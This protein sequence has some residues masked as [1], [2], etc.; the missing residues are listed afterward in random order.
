M[1]C[2]FVHSVLIAPGFQNSSEVSLRILPSLV[3]L[4]PHILI[5]TYNFFAF[6]GL[7]WIVVIDLILFFPTYLQNTF[8]PSYSRP[9][10]Q[11]SCKTFLFSST[12]DWLTLLI[13]PFSF[14]ARR[15]PACLHF[16]L[17]E[18]LFFFPLPWLNFSLEMFLYFCKVELWWD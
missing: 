6:I 4:K 3:S 9:L 16:L 2:Q 13:F 10:G 18:N 5:L 1:Y 14:L 7:P 11:F 12:K 15:N 17:F 8:P